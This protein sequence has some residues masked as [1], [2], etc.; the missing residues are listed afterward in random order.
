MEEEFGP[1]LHPHLVVRL[2]A[3]PRCAHLAPE[4]HVRPTGRGRRRGAEGQRPAEGVEV[5][6]HLTQED[7]HRSPCL[8]R[9]VEQLRLGAPPPVGDREVRQCG[10]GAHGLPGIVR[11]A[12][13]DPIADPLGSG[14][15]GAHGPGHSRD[16]ENA[17]DAGERLAEWRKHE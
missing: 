14:V 11:R 16:G 7:P 10:A 2:G 5:G 8:T 3:I 15:G 6:I 1:A 4:G 12:L 17:T 9:R 13:E